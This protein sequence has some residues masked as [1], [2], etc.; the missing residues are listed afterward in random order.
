MTGQA[1][2]ILGLD[3]GLADTGWG[4]VSVAGN[5]IRY[6]QHGFIRTAAGLPLANRLHVIFSELQAIIE[7]WQPHQAS[8]EALFFAKNVSSAMPV[9]HAR[10]VILLC[11]SLAQLSV[12]EYTPPQIK[13]AVVGTGR[14]E[15]LQVQEM[16][17]LILGLKAIPKPD[18]AADALAAAIC[19]A[20]MATFNRSTSGMG[21]SSGVPQ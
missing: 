4:V 13:Q 15:K 9:A 5:S 14:A 11:C 12:Q 3:P 20:H 17:R 21:T 18:H 16:V 7:Q 1:V 2:R 6:L 10:G 19:H 8:I